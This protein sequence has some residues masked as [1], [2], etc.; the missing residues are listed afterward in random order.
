MMV[1]ERDTPYRAN[2]DRFKC[3][4]KALRLGD[5]AKGHYCRLLQAFV[6]HGGISRID[7]F[8]FVADRK[9]GNWKRRHGASRNILNTGQVC[10]S[11]SAFRFTPRSGREQGFS[12]SPFNRIDS[13]NIH[14]PMEPPMLEAII[15][16]EEVSQLVFLGSPAG[17]VSIGAE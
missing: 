16:D 9:Q 17:L 1:A 4:K 6:L 7:S 11:C 3:R 5:T 15:Q 2:A 13:Q 14:I 10:A 8:N 12:G